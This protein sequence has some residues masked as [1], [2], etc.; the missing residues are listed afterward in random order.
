MDLVAVVTSHIA[1]FVRAS[2]PK[3]AIRILLVA[4]EART[5]ALSSRSLC[6]LSEAAVGTRP[7]VALGIAMVFAFAVTICAG[8][9]SLVGNGAVLGLADRKHAGIQFK[10]RSGTRGL[11]GLVVA[12]GALGV[13]LEKEVLRIGLGR[14]GRFD[15]IRG[16]HRRR[17]KQQ[18]QPHARRTYNNYLLPPLHIVFPSVSCLLR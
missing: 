18:A 10:H 8:R 13:T 11:V 14:Q 15:R 4:F 1:C 6:G 2:G 17:P 12:P 7:L 5:T 3:V 16:Q 9:G